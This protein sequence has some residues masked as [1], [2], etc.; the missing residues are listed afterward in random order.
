MLKSSWKEEWNAKEHIY[1]QKLHHF[2]WIFQKPFLSSIFEWCCFVT[3]FSSLKSIYLINQKNVNDCVYCFVHRINL[4]L[5]LVKSLQLS[6]VD[7]VSTTGRGSEY[8]LFMW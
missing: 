6:P 5:P 3:Y 4:K 8:E 2:T 7:Q 1:E